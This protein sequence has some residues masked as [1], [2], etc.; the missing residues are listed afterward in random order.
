[1]LPP[2]HVETGRRR[3]TQGALRRAAR[4]HRSWAAPGNLAAAPGKIGLGRRASEKACNAQVSDSRTEKGQTDVCGRLLLLLAAAGGG[5]ADSLCWSSVCAMPR[6]KRRSSSGKR[7]L[8]RARWPR[9]GHGPVR[10]GGEINYGPAPSGKGPSASSAAFVASRS[11]VASPGLFVHAAL[12]PGPIGLSPVNPCCPYTASCVDDDRGSAPALATRTEPRDHEIVVPLDNESAY[13]NPL[14][15]K[16]SHCT[17]LDIKPQ[18][19]SD[20]FRPDRS[21]LLTTD[22][23][24]SSV[25]ND[26]SI[27]S[28]IP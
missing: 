17:L 28:P 6:S 14:R 1:M 11:L 22:A 2:E 4:R 23:A 18:R 5:G 7:W 10:G 26:H 27:V 20:R 16:R 15:G 8:K 24:S 9:L 19:M 12:A 25:I 21:R 13:S 3:L